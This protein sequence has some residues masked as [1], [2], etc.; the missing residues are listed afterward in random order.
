MLQRQSEATGLGGGNFSAA[1][2]LQNKNKN[3]CQGEIITSNQRHV[4]D[5]DK[6]PPTLPGYCCALKSRCRILC[7]CD[8][9]SG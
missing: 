3:E 8:N 9:A 4:G 6:E 5:G 2:K 1:E 7:C